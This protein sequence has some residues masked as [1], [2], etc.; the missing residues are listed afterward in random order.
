[1][2]ATD[3]GPTGLATIDSNGLLAAAGAGDGD[4]LVTAAL[5]NNPDIVGRRIIAIRNQGPKDAY[6][7]IQAENYDATS[8]PANAATTWGLGGNE[9]GLQIPMVAN[10][11]W[12]YNNVDVGGRSPKAVEFRLAPGSNTRPR[13]PRSRCGPMRRAAV[14]AA[15]SSAP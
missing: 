6:K 5:K 8:N 10:S 13:T 2:T 1:M 7:M 3:G 15:R 11:T 9:F 4:V 14:Q 12:T